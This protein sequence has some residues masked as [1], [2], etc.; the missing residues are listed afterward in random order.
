MNVGDINP[1][2]RNIDL[3]LNM[4]Y[5]A[6]P[7]QNGNSVKDHLQHWAK[8][9]FGE[10]KCASISEILWKYY[11]L[12]FERKPE[13]MGWSRTEPTTK[14]NFTAYNHFFYGDEAQKRLDWYEALEKQV[15]ILRSQIAAK[16]ADAFYQLVY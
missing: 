6:N 3:F 12:A 2:E 13:F 8:E 5:D 9:I 4:A 7:F 15:K 16:D 1:V 10:E 14:T 11:D